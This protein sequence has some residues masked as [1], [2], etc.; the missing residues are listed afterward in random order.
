MSYLST[1]NIFFIPELILLVFLLLI[2]YGS[3]YL[4]QLFHIL[5]LFIFFGLL[6]VTDDE[7]ITTSSLTYDAT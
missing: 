2:K 6:L 7:T 1:I 4:F 5:V 3:K